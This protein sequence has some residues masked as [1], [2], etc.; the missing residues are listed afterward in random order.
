M[1]LGQRFRAAPDCI[2]IRRSPSPTPASRIASSN[3]SS[4]V[5]SFR[6]GLCGRR[7]FAFELPIDPRNEQKVACPGLHGGGARKKIVGE[8]VADCAYPNLVQ[9][10]LVAELVD[11]IS[12][13]VRREASS[14]SIQ[15][16]RDGIIF[17]SPNI[18]FFPNRTIDASPSLLDVLQCAVRRA[19]RQSVSLAS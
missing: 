7:T 12:S 9:S 3:P 10:P 17:H 2:P 14:T 16:K 11:E 8:G 13:M 4:A 6:A 5:R 19:P 1:L 15:A 18:N